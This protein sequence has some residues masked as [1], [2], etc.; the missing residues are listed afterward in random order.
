M[1]APVGAPPANPIPRRRCGSFSF[2]GRWKPLYFIWTGQGAVLPTAAWIRSTIVGQAI[3]SFHPCV[4]Q[5]VNGAWQLVIHRNI[6]CPVPHFPEFSITREING[7]EHLLIPLLNQLY[8]LQFGNLFRFRIRGVLWEEW[9]PQ[10][11]QWRKALSGPI[12]NHNR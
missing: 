9:R 8:S 4:P 1:Q 3:I 5:F 7:V 10:L 12:H 11:Q 6:L 2:Y